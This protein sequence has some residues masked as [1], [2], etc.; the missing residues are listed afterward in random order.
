MLGI[1]LPET[2]AYNLAGRLTRS[3]DG[4]R[5]ERFSGR[6]GKSSV[7]GSLRLTS[8]PSRPV[9]EGDLAFN[10]LNLADL[11]PVVGADA[12]SL[13]RQPSLPGPGP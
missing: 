6:I 7:A 2:R 1:A 12:V 3:A 5:Y 11:G 8:G 10:S 13:V 4:W 9:L